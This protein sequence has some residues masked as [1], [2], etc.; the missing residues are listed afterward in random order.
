M[1]ILK[2]SAS[3]QYIQ[4]ESCTIH[5][6]DPFISLREEKTFSLF[7]MFV[8]CTA[9]DGLDAGLCLPLSTVGHSNEDCADFS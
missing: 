9:I 4:P 1:L 6:T 3:H 5:V 7:C 2:F 8:Y